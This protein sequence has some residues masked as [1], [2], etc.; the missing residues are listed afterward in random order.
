MASASTDAF[1]SCFGLID[2]NYSRWR[3]FAAVLSFILTNWGHQMEA[4][5]IGWAKLTGWIRKI[6]YICDALYLLLIETINVSKGVS[7]VL[8]FLSPG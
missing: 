8:S 5:K 7:L 1:R 6:K 2:Q 4:K 3:A